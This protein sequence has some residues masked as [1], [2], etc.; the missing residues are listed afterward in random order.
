V[1]RGAQ[2]VILPPTDPEVAALTFRRHL[3][4]FWTNRELDNQGWRL[5]EIDSL[6]T[7]VTIPACRADGAT[8]DYFVRLGAEY[9]DSYPPTVLLV[10]PEDGWPR[11]RA[12]T[13][14]WPRISA[15]SWFGLHDSF[16]FMQ[17]NGQ[18]L[19]EGQLLCFSMTAEYYISNHNPTDDQRWRQ[20]KHTVA[21]TLSRLRELLSPPHYE[22][23]NA[24]RNS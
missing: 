13:M 1:T 16:Q 4:T 3:E 21:A 12:N 18:P 24:T 10:T 20:G 6:H 17:D 11:A 7:V 22:G 14:W 5:V 19:Y 8:D 9:Y 2:A 23:P 15:P